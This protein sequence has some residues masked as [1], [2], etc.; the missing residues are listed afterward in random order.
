LKKQRQNTA[1]KKVR[2]NKND[3]IHKALI[4]QKDK[5]AI[6]KVSS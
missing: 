4:D 1:E 3:E 6:N 2:V 5:H